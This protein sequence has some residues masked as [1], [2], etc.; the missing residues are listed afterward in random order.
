[1]PA[2]SGIFIPT[3]HSLLI[4]FKTMTHNV[5]RVIDKL[6]F[7]TEIVPL[8]SNF[9]HREFEGGWKSSNTSTY[10]GNGTGAEGWPKERMDLI[11]NTVR[12]A[13]RQL[14]NP[15]CSKS[16]FS[17]QTNARNPSRPHEDPCSRIECLATGKCCGG[18]ANE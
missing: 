8:L 13:A 15:F 16:M 10:I 6:S 9:T 14:K 18:D 17:A 1:M 3:H 11:Q 4:D 7:L 5:T 2:R 12:T